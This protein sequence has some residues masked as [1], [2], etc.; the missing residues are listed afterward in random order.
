MSILSPTTF[1]TNLL[2]ADEINEFSRPTSTGCGFELQSTVSALL[3]SRVTTAQRD[4]IPNPVNGMIVYNTTNTVFNYYQNGAWQAGGGPGIAPPGGGTSNNAV[5]R[6]NGLGGAALKNSSL[7]L[8]DSGQLQGVAGLIGVPTYSFAAD[9]TTGIWNPGAGVIEFSGGGDLQFSVASTLNS[10][11]YLQ[12]KGNIAGQGAILTT[13]GA[14]ANI[15]IQLL[16]RG[17]GALSNVAGTVALPSYT[18]TGDTATGIWHSAANTIDFSGNARRQFQITSTASAV[19]FLSV[20][21]D[22]AGVDPVPSIVGSGTDT[23][24]HIGVKTKGNGALIVSDTTNTGKISFANTAASFYTSLQAGA[25]LANVNFVLPIADGTVNNDALI[26]TIPLSS[27]GA[28]NLSF[29]NT[30]VRFASGLLTSNQIKNL[31]T[32]PV[33]LIPAPG[34]DF[35]VVINSF[36]LE[37][38][39]GTLAYTGG[40]FTYLQY[41]NAAGGPGANYATFETSI[42]DTF[43]Q[44]GASS[45]ILTQGS[46]NSTTGLAAT[47]TNNAA[48]TI[49]NDTALFATGDGICRWYA[50]YSIIPIT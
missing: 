14:D 20:H 17:T 15:N 40:G 4:A 42:P 48:I 9:N 30:G 43:I 16:P 22:I 18:F 29:D 33:E 23:R 34:A 10:V 26:D 39:F 7:L 11:N 12:A 37:T 3:V 2:I 46:M 24:I 31:N 50:W 47:S 38:V 27:D 44:S 25:V 5:A 36:S 32:T 1:T 8:P 35:M 28:G 49:T 41:G 19:N 21:G 6:W 13:V 45:V